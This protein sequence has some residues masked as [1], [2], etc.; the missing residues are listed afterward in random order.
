MAYYFDTSALVK[1]LVDEPETLALQS[2]A[3]LRAPRSCVL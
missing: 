1:L 3:V 2:M